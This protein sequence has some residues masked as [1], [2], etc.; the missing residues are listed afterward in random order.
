MTELLATNNSEQQ[1]NDNSIDNVNGP[2]ALDLPEPLSNTN[3]DPI[4][5]H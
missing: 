4:E 1:I 3:T 5:T 2:T